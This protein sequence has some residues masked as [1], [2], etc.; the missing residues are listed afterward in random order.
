[1]H[2]VLL[3][4]GNGHT[5][6]FNL[7]KELI[8]FSHFVSKCWEETF[9]FFLPFPILWKR[10]KK[11]W[12]DQGREPEKKSGVSLIWSLLNNTAVIFTL[13]NICIVHHIFHYLQL[14]WLWNTRE[15]QKHFCLAFPTQ[16]ASIPQS[17]LFCQEKLTRLLTAAVTMGQPLEQVLICGL[18]II[19]IATTP[20]LHA[21]VLAT[22]YQLDRK[23]IH[24]SLGLTPLIWLSLRCLAL[25]SKMALM[26]LCSY[27]CHTYILC[28]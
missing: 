24:S 16:V 27:F 18:E 25:K 8:S 6:D 28:S 22:R 14:C 23:P 26:L 12:L 21:L 20:V 1:M 7:P 9:H 15:I 11:V 5:L 10:Q 19:Q 17:C 13:V 3:E 4:R 2:L